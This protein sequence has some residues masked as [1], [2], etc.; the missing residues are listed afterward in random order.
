LAECNVLTKLRSIVVHQ[1]TSVTEPEFDQVFGHS[2]P[3]E[4]CGPE[5]AEGVEST[6]VFQQSVVEN[7]KDV[8]L[9]ERRTCPRAEQ[10][11]VLSLYVVPKK[12]GQRLSDIDQTLRCMWI[13]DRSGA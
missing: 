6:N 10:I 2:F 7:S 9:E 5:A 3:A 8:A 12:V 4:L 1:I 11:A 13:R